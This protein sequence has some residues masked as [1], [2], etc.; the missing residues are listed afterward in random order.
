[1]VDGLQDL[2]RAMWP[3]TFSIEPVLLYLN[4]GEWTWN[5][6]LAGW[7]VNPRYW[8]GCFEATIKSPSTMGLA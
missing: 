7:E 4:V 5:P 2:T 8:F 6:R 1:M 3:W